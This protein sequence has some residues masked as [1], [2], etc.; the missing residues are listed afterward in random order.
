MTSE[1]MALLMASDYADQADRRYPTK[2]GRT[3]WF[4]IGFFA[5][6]TIGFLI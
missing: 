1:E 5:G 4:L 2:P 6:L 3:K